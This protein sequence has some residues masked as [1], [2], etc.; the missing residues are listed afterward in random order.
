MR[1]LC[2]REDAHMILITKSREEQGVRHTAWLNQMIERGSSLPAFGTRKGRVIFYPRQT[3]RP[4]RRSWGKS[5]PIFFEEGREFPKWEIR[6][7]EGLKVPLRSQ[8]HYTL[9]RSRKFQ[10]VRSGGFKRIKDE[11]KKDKLAREGCYW[12]SSLRGLPRPTRGSKIIQH[13]FLGSLPVYIPLSDVRKKGMLAAEDFI[14]RRDPIE[15]FLTR[16]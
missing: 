3:G 1:K 6:A 14:V 7:R 4:R 15:F 12:T 11:Y 10:T 5:K 16:I 13:Y 9:A 2:L 8:C